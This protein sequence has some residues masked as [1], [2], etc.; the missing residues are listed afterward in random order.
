MSPLPEDA[1]F[2]YGVAF[3]G[4]KAPTWDVVVNEHQVP[5]LTADLRRDGFVTLIINDRMAVDIP[6]DDPKFLDSIVR[7]VAD[8]IAVAQGRSCHPTPGVPNPPEYD[9]RQPRRVFT[10]GE[11]S[12]GGEGE[13]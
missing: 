9:T 2:D 6:S 12:P 7:F 10:V 13:R 4:P 11:M 5:L 1:P 8:C 3:P